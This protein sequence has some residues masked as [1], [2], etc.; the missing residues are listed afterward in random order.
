MF[1]LDTCVLSEGIRPVPDVGVDSWF[2]AQDSSDLF[3][4]A[5]T[6]GEL[7]YGIDKLPQGRKREGLS[8]WLAE[9]ISLGF[10]GR[11][12]AFDLEAASCWA[13]IRS[14][15]PNAQTIDSQIG[16]T[17]IAHG[18]TLVTRNVRDFAFEGLAVFNP[19]RK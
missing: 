17:A 4:S 18:Y 5:L 3:I 12:L 8:R 10:A 1:L 9:T 15:H 6:A 7:R 2:K 16:A 13:R 14:V 11:I 19:W